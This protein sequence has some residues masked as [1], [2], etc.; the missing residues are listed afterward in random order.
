MSLSGR[1]RRPKPAPV[2]WPAHVLNATKFGYELSSLRDFDP[3]PTPPTRPWAPTPLSTSSTASRQT[4]THPGKKKPFKE[5]RL[6]WPFWGRI[7]GPPLER[8][9]AYCTMQQPF[10]LT[11]S[12]SLSAMTLYGRYLPSWRVYSTRYAR[13]LNLACG[14]R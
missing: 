7:C 1:F 10:P 3:I 2:P 11:D 8:A 4:D 12:Q 6:C 5:A 13:Y 9:P 14:N